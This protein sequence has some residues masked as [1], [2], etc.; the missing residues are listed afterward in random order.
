MERRRGIRRSVSQDEP[1]GHARLRTGG[2]L[3]I[4]EASS[5]GALAQTTDRLLPGRQLDV[6]IVSADGRALVRCRVAR[7]FVVKVDADV[8]HYQ[9]ALSFDRAID[10]R[11]DGYALPPPVLVGEA[12]RG[13]AYPERPVCR[14][15][16]FSEPPSFEENGASP[17]LAPPLV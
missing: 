2:R 8:M 5:W 17:T 1:L 12:D 15:I 4:L 10:V 3:R 14:D 16:E 13:I 11:L 9:V 6:H 7:A